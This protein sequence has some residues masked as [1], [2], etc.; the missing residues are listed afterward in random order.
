MKNLLCSLPAKIAAIMLS[1]IMVLVIVLSSAAAIVMGYMEF[2]THS[3]RQMQKTILYEMAVGDGYWLSNLLQNSGLNTLREEIGDMASESNIAY[4]VK[5]TET[6]E[7]IYTNFDGTETFFT[8]TRVENGYEFI[9]HVYEEMPFD[10]EYAFVRSL[11]KT[12]HGLRYAVFVFA[13]MGL[14]ILIS[15]VCFL[16]CAAGRR[17]AYSSIQLN[18]LDRIPFDICLTFLS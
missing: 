16:C 5:S 7:T 18:F 11:V 14:V 15:L 6:D 10:D 13:F 12:G 1:Y 4:T 3:S 9:I 8:H 2:Y 17:F